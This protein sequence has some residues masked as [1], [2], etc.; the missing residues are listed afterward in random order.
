MVGQ[1]MFLHCGAISWG[2]VLRG[3][4]AA[5][6]EQ[7]FSHFLLYPQANWALVVPIVY[8]LGPCG[9]LQ[10]TLLWG[11]EFLLPLHTPQVLQ[12]EVWRLSF[13]M[14]EPWVAWSVLLPVVPLVYLCK[15]VGLPAWPAV[16]HLSSPPATLP[17]VLSALAAHLCPSYQSEWMFLL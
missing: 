14:L 4:N 2:R 5:F 11:W 17:W 8:I 1:P 15:N 3:N 9:S 10:R 13:P 6:L 12:P 16:A 7:V